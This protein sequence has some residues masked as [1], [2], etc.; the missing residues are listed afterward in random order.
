MV[1]SLAKRLSFEQMSIPNDFLKMTA[2][3]IAKKY[4]N[5]S[6]VKEVKAILKAKV[7][8]ETQAPLKRLWNYLQIK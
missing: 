8:E 1:K 7:K 2:Y 4:K 6:L 3:G 5:P